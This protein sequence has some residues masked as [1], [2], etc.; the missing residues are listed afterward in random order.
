M[1]LKITY[2]SEPILELDR[3]ITLAV[4]KLG[5]KFIGQGYD[6]RKKVRDIEFE[7]KVK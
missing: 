1:N 7:K 3:K 5:Y 4:I 6:L 2:N